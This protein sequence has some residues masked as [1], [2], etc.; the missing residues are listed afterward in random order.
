MLNKKI[1]IGFFISVLFLV[2][3][4][5][6]ESITPP[7][8]V[9]QNFISSW[10]SGDYE[11]MYE[12]L[13]LSSQTNLSAE[14]F[15]ELFQSTYDEIK[16]SDIAIQLLQP[17][18][19][20]DESARGTEV[21]LQYE[22]SLS[23]FTGDLTFDSIATMIFDEEEKK[24][25]VE[26]TPSMIFPLM[27]DDDQ[28]KL[29]IMFPEERGEIYDR[30]GK[31]L[32]I[33]AEIYEIGLVPGRMENEEEI[34]EVSEKVGVSVEYI[35]AQLD[36]SWVG[37]DTFVP[38]K[39]VGS[40]EKEFVE[41]LYESI[42]VATYREVSAR[43]Y[44]AGEAAAHLIGYIGMVRQEELENDTDYKYQNDSTIG[45]TG[46]EAIFEERLRGQ[47]GGEVYIESI[48]GIEKHIIQKKESVNGESIQLT[49]DLGIQEAMFDKF[50][51]DQDMG[52]GVAIHPITGE[53][54]ALV[55]YPSYNPNDFI[56]GM[57][58]EQYTE[59]ESDPD[60]PLTNRFAQSF[61]PGSTIKPITAAIA[62]ENG[63]DPEVRIESSDAG[64]K[65]D[66]SWGNHSVRRVS[67]PLS[68]L[69]LNEA[70]M[71]SDNIYFA[72]V[73]TD[74]GI[75]SFEEG[76]Q[77]F[78]FNEKLPFSYPNFAESQ[79]A[80][81]QIDSDVLLADTA[82]GQGQLLVNPLHLALMYSTFVNNGSIPNPILLEEEQPT[83]WL[84]GVISEQN[85]SIVLDAMIEVIQNH[86]GTASH[87][88][89]DQV[90]LAGKTGT[91]EHKASRDAES[92][93][94]ETGWFIGMDVEDPELLILMMMEN[95]EDKRSS[96]YVASKVKELFMEIY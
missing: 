60:R 7:E 64:W 71:Y 9:F 57:S 12:Y 50:D 65:K 28:V 24:W 38:I 49:M 66:E 75:E 8:E 91:A 68:Q 42:P 25:G 46:L 90:K 29:R 34:D 15:K 84:E 11:D 20:E 88:N 39:K 78:A 1:Y 4:A 87:V 18:I 76:L 82:Y 67:N 19:E 6:S 55:N 22:K 37:P 16:A 59:L 13:T 5:C 74:L 30:N 44:P 95:V 77:Q 26:W 36:Q 32:A 43:V 89:L 51:Q 3:A 48:D 62:L 92:G 96:Y 2:L 94:A 85:A 69:N 70:M 83:F 45:R 56:L 10:E 40:N 81:N 58:S 86:N 41:E 61:I 21:Q 93:G 52:T 47:S 79:I 14:E 54:L 31:P 63:L 27:E 72:K 53:V 35:Q 73:A 33:N 80:Q 17:E 23:M